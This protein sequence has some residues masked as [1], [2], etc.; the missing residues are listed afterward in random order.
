[1]RRASWIAV[2]AVAAVLLAA[3]S[4]LPGGA[5]PAPTL[6]PALAP[7]TYTSAAFQPAVTYTVPSGWRVAEDSPGYFALQPVTSEIT[8]IHI[9]ANPLAAS[10]NPTCPTTAEPGVGTGSLELAAWI[11]GL[12]GF[13]ASSPRMATV[14]GLRGVELDLAINSGWTASCPFANGVPTV[15]LFVG[16]DGNLRWVVAGNERLRLDLLDEP[17]G[18]T[19]VVDIDA[20]D[21]TLFDDLLAA[22][23]PIVQSFSF[24]TP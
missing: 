16:A 22:A 24:A 18:R 6:P 19:V 10:Q 20:F 14:G 1:V 13:V 11:R 15:P 12:P 21:G 17:G 5:T 9:F 23:T 2:A 3:C 4:G 7:G 8:G